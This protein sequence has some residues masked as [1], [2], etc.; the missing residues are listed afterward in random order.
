MTGFAQEKLAAILKL[1]SA[2]YS[3]ILPERL[4]WWRAAIRAAVT[5]TTSSA[6]PDLQ[7]SWCTDTAYARAGRLSTMAIA[8]VVEQ[9]DDRIL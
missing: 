9:A 4:T 3:V 6:S 2:C 1:V 7:L 8:M 5:L